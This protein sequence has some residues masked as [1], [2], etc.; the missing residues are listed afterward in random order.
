MTVEQFLI[1]NFG[2]LIAAAGGIFLKRVSENMSGF[3]TLSAYV[4]L[5]ADYNLWLG[6]ICY[7]LPIFFW[8]YLLKDMELTKLQPMLS[9]VYVY[10]VI[11]AFFFLGETPGTERILGIIVIAVG[12]AL[13]SRS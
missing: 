12:V 5:I 7:V 13:V 10:S 9:I 6:G 11:F 1:I 2:A 3:T 4:G 8:A